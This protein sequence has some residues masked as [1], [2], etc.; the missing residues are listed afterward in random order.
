MNYLTTCFRVLL[1]CAMF[2][3]GVS[4]LGFGVRDEQRVSFNSTVGEKARW[5]AMDYGVVADDESID[6]TQALQRSLNAAGEAGG[7]IV[8]LPSGRFRFDGVLTIPAG[9]TLQGTYRVPPTIVNKDEK[10]TGTTLLTYANRGM[11]DA[12]PFINLEGSNSAL[13]GVA[14]IYPEWKQTDVPPVPYPPCVASKNT[15]NVAVIDCCLLNPYEGIHFVLAH[16]HLVRNV[17]GYPSW[18]GL[19]V[20]ECYDIGHVENVHYWPFGVTYKP[21]DPYCEWVNINGTA[22]ELART[23]WH[24]VSNTFCF[25]YGCGY[26]FSDKGHGGTN[27]NFLGIGADSCRRAVLVE[28]AQKQGLLIT[29]GEFVGRWTSEDSVCLEI[30]RENEGAVMLTNCSFWGPVKTCVWSRSEK[31]RVVLNGCEFVNWNEVHSSKVKDGSPAVKID[32]GRA[33]LLGNSFEQPGTHLYVG[34]AAAYVTAT[35]NQAIGGFRV[36]GNKSPVRV[37]LSANE[38]DLLTAIPEGR[39]N[40]VVR[41][42]SA[43]DVRFIK[44]WYGPE[45]NVLNTFRWSGGVSWLLLPISKSESAVHVEID[46]EAPREALIST[47]ADSSKEFGV[48]IGETKVAD[49]S[50][51]SNR[52]AF[53]VAPE[54]A[55]LTDEGDLLIEIRCHAW[56]PKE[57]L[58]G[59]D[60]E[61]EIGVSCSTV[62]VKTQGTTVGKTFD[63]NTG[64]WL[65]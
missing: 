40:Y 3:V 2:T 65:D 46:L 52:I 7:G 50:S 15:C 47:A 5:N 57:F 54:K 25:G 51:G 34:E 49:L 4:C 24:Y 33:T 19:F 17:T 23:D 48:F 58:E 56:K 29:N 32:A 12:E 27:G 6:N 9:V 30:G 55:N 38:E 44:G 11:Y 8:E 18:R 26:L 1:V 21:D 64:T 13:I 16:R 43:G 28:Q 10:P 22:F 59:S 37:Q 60:D 63:G 36:V 31:G 53:D 39:E 41:I 42:G 61:R 35:G 45:K 62:R 20:D 14:V